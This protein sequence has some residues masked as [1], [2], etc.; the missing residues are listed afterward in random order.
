LFS[1]GRF[2]SS[3]G[4]G[5]ACSLGAPAGAVWAAADPS[6]MATIAVANTMP[7]ARMK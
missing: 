3:D 1:A 6:N 7:L 4:D 5:V 2:G